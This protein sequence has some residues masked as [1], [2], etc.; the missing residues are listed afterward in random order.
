MSES[1]PP[2]KLK[3]TS[4][5]RPP[6]EV[7][8]TPSTSAPKL[9]LKLKAKENPQS[10]Q[11]I[12]STSAPKV[13]APRKSQKDKPVRTSNPTSKKRELEASI[14]SSDDDDDITEST[15]QSLKKK[16][17]IKLTLKSS[18]IA[19]GIPLAASQP[20][21]PQSGGPNRIKLNY[22]RTKGAK[23]RTRKPAG[24][25]YDSEAPDA[26]SD[27]AIEE[28]FILRMQPGE[29]CEYLRQ[30]IAEQRFGQK[31]S[32]GADVRM[33]FLDRNGRKAAVHIRGSLYAAA[34]V[35]LPCIVEGMKSWDKKSWYKSV[36]ICQM[37]LVLGRIKS[38]D[39][40]L[41]YPLPKGVD[42]KT[43]QFAHGLTPPMRQVRTRRFRKRISRTAIE[44]V[45][46]QVEAL[47]RKDEIAEEEGLSSEVT[48]IE[49]G[50]LTEERNQR[51]QSEA[52]RQDTMDFGEA[53]AEGEEDDA[54]DQQEQVIHEEED[55]EGLADELVQGM[56]EDTEEVADVPMPDI[57]VATPEVSMPADSS[58]S[59]ASPASAVVETP[60]ATTPS[61]A[62]TSGDEGSSDEDEV[63]GDEAEE[64]E[65]AMEKQ[66][67]LQ[68]QRAEI[69]DLEDSIK[70]QQ[71][72]LERQ[73]NPIF[74]R[75]LLSKIQTLKEELKLRRGAAGEHGEEED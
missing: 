73:Q 41:R 75:K 30:A 32:E 22:N 50:R 72:E 20:T 38:E 66:Q 74:K 3:F 47:L 44:Q 62:A 13:K 35:D 21:A 68:R 34:M 1:R 42:A 11:P 36:D 25:G 18:G 49:V 7:P 51:L 37:L 69:Q 40:A 33:V 59:A 52:V 64:D 46:T 53:D 16:P 60:A 45:E 71:S 24:T 4:S 2:L 56:M 57:S 67:D 70:T 19:H 17:A 39:E 27:P 23:L 6:S 5:Q 58:M 48:I 63:S 65:D 15:P 26:E 12:P 43:M 31:G 9:K 55:S 29:D 61:K 54:M 10:Q 28:D 14:L 8:E